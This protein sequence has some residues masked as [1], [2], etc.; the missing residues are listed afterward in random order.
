MVVKL[1]V[2]GTHL[3]PVQ[4][5]YSIIGTSAKF[6]QATQVLRTLQDLRLCMLV[7]PGTITFTMFAKHITSITEAQT[8]K[9]TIS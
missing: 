3:N 6:I 7:I 8:D 1:G 2:A 9:L 4:A 5:D